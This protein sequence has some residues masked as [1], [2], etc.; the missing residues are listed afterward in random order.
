MSSLS[1]LVK[2]LNEMKLPIEAKYLSQSSKFTVFIPVYLKDDEKNF[3]LAL[4]SVISNSVVPDEILIV[5][6]GPVTDE[7]DQL[8]DVYKKQLPHVIKVIQQVH[9]KGRGYTAANAVRNAK[10]ELIAR[11]DADDISNFQRFERQ[12]GLIQTNDELTVVGGQI[13]EFDENLELNLRR[14]VPIDHE[15]IVEFSRLRSP[16]NQPTVLFRKSAVL[17]AGNYSNLTVMEDYDL[18][19]RMIENGM[20]FQNIDENLVYMRAPKDLYQRRGGVQYLKTYHKFR[21]QLLRK[22]LISDR[23]YYKSIIGM[24]ISSLVPNSIREKLY[25][26]LLRGK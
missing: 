21:K 16:I 7:M 6:D 18:W 1:N 24:S 2:I 4:K 10:N 23:D 11:M 12:L 19:M 3:E 25:K 14:I 9:N 5:F 8:V 26:L 15:K 17:K 20:I 13:A 22:N